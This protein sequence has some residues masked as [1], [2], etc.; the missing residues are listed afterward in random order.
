MKS[1]ICAGILLFSLCGVAF[2]WGENLQSIQADFEQ[3]I[4][5]EDGIPARYEGH[6][7]G[8]APNKVKWQYKTPLQKEIYMNEN[9]V[10]IYEPLLAQVSHSYL[11]DQTD[12]ISIIK[13]AKEHK[14]GT[15]H[16]KVDGVNYVIFLDDS[17][18]PQRIE[19]TDSMGAKTTLKLRNV[20]L[21]VNLKDSNFNFILPKGVEVV[22]LRN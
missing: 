5:N 14:D 6:I 22:E 20:K 17:K 9:E 16:T 11:K 15:Y 1:I 12:F 8:K 13:S 10:L 4:V 18:K 7:M 19:F 2:G 21:N 3:T